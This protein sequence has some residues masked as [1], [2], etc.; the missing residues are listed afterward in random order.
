[1]RF[2]SVIPPLVGWAAL[3][4]NEM[5]GIGLLIVGFVFVWVVSLWAVQMKVAPNWY[6]RLRYPLTAI[7]VCLILVVAL[8]E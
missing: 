8:A 2:L 7:V 3:L 5:F 6:L 1:M 4:T